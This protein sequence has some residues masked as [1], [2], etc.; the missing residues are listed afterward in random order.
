MLLNSVFNY[1][2]FTKVKDGFYVGNSEV[3]PV[4]CVLVVQEIAEEFP[5][6][7]YSL[8]YIQMLRVEESSSLM[9]AILFVTH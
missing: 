9:P 8:R 4:T 5:W 6:F 2:G 3:S 1:Y 7:S